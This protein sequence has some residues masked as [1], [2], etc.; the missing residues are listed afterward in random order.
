MQVI[1]FDP[2]KNV[3]VAVVSS[4][5]ELLEHRIVDLAAVPGLTIPAGARVVVGG[6]TGSRRL[7]AALRLAGHEPEV[8]DETSTT[9][10][11]RLLYYLHH[12]PRGLARLLPPGMRAPPVPLDDFAA[13][14]IALR[15]LA[16]EAEAGRHAEPG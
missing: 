4:A 7:A 8:V 12:P 3:G 13:Y 16:V 10:E 11:A 15:F 9:I 1:A 14:A 5:G 2:G 6:G